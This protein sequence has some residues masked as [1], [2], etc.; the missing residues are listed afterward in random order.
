MKLNDL[1][2]E[3]IAKAAVIGKIKEKYNIKEEDLTA[4]IE[5]VLYVNDLGDSS[6][7]ILFRPYRGDLAEAMSH[8][9]SIR[10]REDLLSLMRKELKPYKVDVRD[11]LL[12]IAYYYHDDRMDWDT[13]IVTLEGYGIY[14]FTNGPL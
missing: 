10:N 11:D 12:K 7:K 6:G 8:V 3:Q 5:A 2:M 1:S 9:K 4:L 14:G 13:Y